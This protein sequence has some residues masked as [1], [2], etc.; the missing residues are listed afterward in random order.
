MKSLNLAADS[1]VKFCYWNYIMLSTKNSMY[2]IKIRA[3][4]RDSF[5]RSSQGSCRCIL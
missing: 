2:V 4:I 1:M 5:D 3:E